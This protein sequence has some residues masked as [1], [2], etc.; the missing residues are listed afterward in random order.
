MAV[1]LGNTW[2]GNEWLRSLSHI[3]YENRIPRGA[4]YAR[5]GKVREIKIDGNL[6]KARVAGSSPR[7]YSV[8]VT[9]PLFL[10]SEKNRLMDELM[11]YPGVISR[12]L[13]REL[14]PE[15]LRIADACGLKIF[16]KRWTDFKMDCNCPDWAVPC[17]H[18]A[19]VVYM[20]SREIDNN[21]FLVF[22]MHGMD[23]LA[24]LKKRGVTVD[25]SESSTQIPLLVDLLEKEKISKDDREVSAEEIPFHRINFATLT[26]R[27]KPLL[28]LL[29]DNP[30]FCPIGNFKETYMKGMKRVSK[31][32]CRFFA[33][34]LTPEGLLAEPVLEYRSLADTPAAEPLIAVDTDIRFSVNDQLEWQV[35]R[36]H[37]E[38]SFPALPLA[39]L[40]LNPDF[41]PDYQPS[42]VAAHQALF[43]SLHLIAKG[44]IVLQIVQL[45][46]KTYR[47]CWTPA[48]IDPQVSEMM[49]QLNGFIPQDM[50]QVTVGKRKT[51]FCLRQRAEWIVTFFLDKLMNTL[52]GDAN[53]T[54][55][56]QLFFKSRPFLFN[57]VGEREIPGA[58]KAWTDH[59]RLAESDYRPVFSVT[60]N[61]TAGFDLHIGVEDKRNPGNNAVSLDEVLNDERYAST[62]FRILR[63]FTLLSSLLSEV[64]DYI[65]MGAKYPIRYTSKTFVP[66]LQEVIPTMQLLDIKVFMP[67]SLRTL[68]R[69][70]PTVRLSVKSDGKAA[71]GLFDLFNFEWQVAVGDELLS[72]A[73]FNALQ[74]KAN[75]LIRF[76]QSYMYVDA[77]DLNKLSEAFQ[78]G[79]NLSPMQ[80][81]QAALL[82][83]YESAPIS[84][85]PEARLLI[86]ELTAQ[87]DI[88]LP[89]GLH[90]TLRPYQERGYSW[91]YRN[92]RIGFGSILAD[93]MGLGKT[94]QSIT[95]L[96]KLKEEGA[97]ADK[98]V[99]IV[100]PT[101]L[102]TN[103]MAEIQRFAP[104]LTVMTYHGGTRDL[105]NFSHDIL[106]TTYGVLR[107]DAA[108]L[109]KKPWRVMFIDEAQNI[110][111]HDTAQSKSVRAIP[112]DV[113][114]ALSGT[115]I[116][117]RLSEFWSIMDYANKGYLDTLKNFKE[118]YAQPIQLYNDADCALRFRKV[119]APFMMRRMKTDKS[120]INDLPDKIELNDYATLKSEQAALYQSTLDAAMREI[121]GISTTD[122]ESLFKRQGLILQMILALK[123]I[124]NHPAQFLKNGDTRME[125]SGK[126][127]MLADRVESI[128]DG[129]EKVLIF[130]QFREMG[131]LL[132]RFIEE[133]I[134]QR[135]MFYHG[136][137]SLKERQE[138]V[139]RFQNNRSDKVF[140]LSLK[141]AG[142]GLNLT[143][144]SHVIHYD[145]WWNPAVEAQATDRAYR[146]GQQKNVMVHRFITQGTF[147]ERINDMIQQKKHLAEMTVTS[148]ESWIGKLSNKE[149]REIFG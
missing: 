5:S 142:T 1:K 125:L 85:S 68:L 128:V 32:A 28:L 139:D 140:I 31:D 124:C 61:D 118:R 143:A 24:E 42:V 149:L 78:K 18:L 108:K 10:E 82:G 14:A 91:M 77:D 29:P 135:P 113:H 144:A 101:G 9:V 27:M 110:K 6:I 84:I 66:F 96:L 12:L 105:K 121:E 11:R 83:E 13:N 39:L 46:D 98:Q 69:P 50:L 104:S 92:L 37:P 114:I 8:S 74:K 51:P 87:E 107:S 93:D 45:A 119:T 38:A 100:V 81:F 25:V 147:E 112:A 120:I 22:E 67:K 99:L 102:L 123:Q 70:K 63:S 146:I 117:N 65:S 59:C 94:L 26:E 16:P 41:L 55:F 126:A 23:L 71:F 122:N 145:L 58:V 7:P 103:W 43:L 62:R 76:K 89:Q 116:E 109:K 73:D 52:S 49:K 36:L 30:T 130:T 79:D 141:A 17:K 106:L 136:G 148:G 134:G 35:S 86:D 15:I 75:G 2:W 138:M 56:T 97:L 21:P 90:A 40:K 33:G 80:I 47:I 19:A 127:E 44:N 57:G 131:D 133:R 129:N 4:T 72:M 34:K 64:H 88:A 115:P 48:Y 137:C 60:E 132:M 111:N 54:V 3:D 53:P 95:L 20:V